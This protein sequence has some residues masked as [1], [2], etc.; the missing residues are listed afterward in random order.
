[1]GRRADYRRALQG[2]PVPD[3]PAYLSANSGLPG[4]RGNL[5]L[6]EAVA[7]EATPG[8]ADAL[9]VTD[10]EFLVVCGVVGL[11]AQLAG[12]SDGTIEARLHRFA[13]DSR[14][15]VREAVAMALQR[16][17]DADFARLQEI[18]EAWSADEG[19]LVMRAA[20]AAVC[21]PRLLRSREAAAVALSSCDRVTTA[22]AGLPVGARKDPDVRTLRQALGYCWSVATAADPEAGLARFQALGGVDDPDVRWIVKQNSRKARLAR[23]L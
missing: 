13:G 8:M 19:P 15:R 4:P 1:M 11:G 23:Y 2:I 18:V 10:D 3:W 12:G 20:I 22:L 16:L 21:E 5:E 17:G 14:W 7:D 6:V 9:I